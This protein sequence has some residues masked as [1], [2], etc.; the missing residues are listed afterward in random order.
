LADFAK[1]SQNHSEWRPNEREIET[2]S[3]VIAGIQ[4]AAGSLGARHAYA[5]HQRRAISGFC[6]FLT[7]PSGY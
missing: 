6:A 4:F 3:W 5:V 2:G 1:G 7:L